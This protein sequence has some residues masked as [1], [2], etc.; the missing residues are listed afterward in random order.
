MKP[1]GPTGRLNA[2]GELGLSRSIQLLEGIQ[3]PLDMDAFDRLL[4]WLFAGSVG[5]QSRILILFALKAQPLNAQQ[6]A[7]QLKLD[8]TTVRHHL[9]VLE[10]NRI[11]I[12]EGEKYGKVYF[13]TDIM[14]SHWADLEAIIEKTRLSKRRIDR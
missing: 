10:K 7:E 4:W 1:G 14:E 2:K 6:L 13:I 3:R 9:S 12:T 5:A 11:L 8:Y